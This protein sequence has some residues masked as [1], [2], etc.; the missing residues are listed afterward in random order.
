MTAAGRPCARMGALLT[1]PLCDAI[2]FMYPAFASFKALES[3]DRADDT[4]WVGG[5]CWWWAGGAAGGAAV[6][7]RAVR[8]WGGRG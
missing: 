8:G 1:K 4:Q 6:P 7:G 2:G 3:V 5:G